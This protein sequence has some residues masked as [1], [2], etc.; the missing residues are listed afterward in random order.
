[1]TRKLLPLPKLRATL[2][3]CTPARPHD[4]QRSLGDKVD[5]ND[6]EASDWA[7]FDDDLRFLPVE[8]ATTD[9]A[10][11]FV[12]LPIPLSLNDLSCENDVFEVEDGEVFIFKLFGRMG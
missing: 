3:S 7:D 5:R 8:R 11:G 10:F 2:R 4:A 1:M 9:D 6:E 12:S